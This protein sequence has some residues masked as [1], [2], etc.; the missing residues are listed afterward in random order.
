[1]F[2]EE[3][4]EVCSHVVSQQVSHHV[5]AA[6]GGGQ[7]QRGQQ[8]LVSVGETEHS[9]LREILHG[10]TERET[11]TITT[12]RSSREETVY[13]TAR[14]SPLGEERRFTLPLDSVL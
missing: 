3:R 8:K 5:H 12:P 6:N 9:C 2:E 11:E 4:E 10:N 7:V 13:T 14:F 1:M